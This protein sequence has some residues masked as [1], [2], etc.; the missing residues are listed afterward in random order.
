MEHIIPSFDNGQR[1]TLTFTLKSPPKFYNIRSTDDLHLYA[2]EE[3]PQTNTN[4]ILAGLA[5]LNLGPK[6]KANRLE[7]LCGLSVSNTKNSALCMVYKIAFFDT[8]SAQTALNFVRDFTVPDV[9]CW[10]TVVPAN[11]TY[12][13]E[14]EYAVVENKLSAYNSSTA[15]EFNFAIRYQLM[16]LVLEGTIAPL[17]M[18]DLIPEVHR[19]AKQHGSDFTAAAVRRLGQQIPTPGPSIDAQDFKVPTFVTLLQESIKD[20]KARALT[21]QDLTVKQ[22]KHHHLALTYKA[23]VTPTGILLRGPDWGVSNRILRKYTTR[24]EYFMRVFFADEDGLSVFHDPRAS[25][26]HVY[27]RFRSVLQ[28]GISV[29]GRTFQFLGFSHASLRSHQAWFMAPFESDGI[30]VR[31]RDIIRDL[32]DFTHIHCSAKCAARYEP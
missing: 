13:I 21:A 5:N 31:A 22:K 6:V 29:G 3:A 2:G 32:G 8:R 16:A 26:E 11:R 28:N 19:I 23:T 24:T 25:Q 10:K 1:A 4:A 27:E 12:T 30:V 15:Q 14:A 18:F 9:H 17:K 7:R 20:S